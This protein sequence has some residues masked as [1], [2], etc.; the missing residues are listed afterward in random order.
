MRQRLAKI[1]VAVEAV[2]AEA[3]IMGAVALATNSVAGNSGDGFNS[4]AFVGMLPRRLCF[5]ITNSPQ[6]LQTTRK[7][8]LIEL[9]KRSLIAYLNNRRAILTSDMVNA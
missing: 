5:W 7:G 8:K 4:K 2:S 3:V 1:A 9:S 6:Q